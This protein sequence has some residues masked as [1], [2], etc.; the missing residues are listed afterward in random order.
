[1]KKKKIFTRPEQRA[2]NVTNLM[3]SLGVESQLR[4]LM[5]EILEGDIERLGEFA[6]L[7]Q[8]APPEMKARLLDRLDTAMKKQKGSRR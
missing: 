7:I 4:L 6:Q 8:Y 2:R 3:V 5:D 1:M